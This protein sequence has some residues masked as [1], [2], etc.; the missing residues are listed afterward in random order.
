MTIFAG[1]KAHHQNLPRSVLPVV[2]SI[3]QNK[4]T[5]DG[6]IVLVLGCVDENLSEVESS[7]SDIEAGDNKTSK[8]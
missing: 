5:G 6:S 8:D 3:V 7:S 2:F 1:N 4:V